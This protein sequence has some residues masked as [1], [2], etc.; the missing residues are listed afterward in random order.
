MERKFVFDLISEECDRQRGKWGK[1]TR[2]HFV[3]SV[4]LLEEVGEVA[5]AILEADWDQMRAE[6]IQCAAVIVSWLCDTNAK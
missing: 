5:K 2:F 3:W 6:L 4:I 1:Q